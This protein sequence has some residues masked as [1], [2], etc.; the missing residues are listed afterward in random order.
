MRRLKNGQSTFTKLRTFK[1]GFHCVILLSSVMS[2]NCRE[3]LGIGQYSRCS[4]KL[5]ILEVNKYSELDIFQNLYVK[6]QGSR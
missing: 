3:Q 5:H 2:V 6:F 1:I 4:L